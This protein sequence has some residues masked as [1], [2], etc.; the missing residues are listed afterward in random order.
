VTPYQLATLASRIDPERC[1]T[2]PNEAIAAAERLLKTI[3][4]DREK[5]K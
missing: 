1:S 4:Q 3:E 2:N 5:R